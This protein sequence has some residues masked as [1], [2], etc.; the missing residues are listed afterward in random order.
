L[1]ASPG[2]ILLALTPK[3]S[4]PFLVCLMIQALLVCPREIGPPSEHCR[5]NYEH[6]AKSFSAVG[7]LHLPSGKDWNIMGGRRHGTRHS[8]RKFQKHTR[9]NRGRMCYTNKKCPFEERTAH[10]PLCCG[11]KWAPYAQCC[12]IIRKATKGRRDR[13]RLP[14]RLG[15]NKAKRRAVPPG[16]EAG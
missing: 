11:G 1:A 7:N 2:A 15:S 10:A 12:T 14:R 5:S 6:T 16:D 4:M 8:P 3:R 13:S 9:T